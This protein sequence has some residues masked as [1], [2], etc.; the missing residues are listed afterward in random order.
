MSRSG[1]RCALSHDAALAKP[2]FEVIRILEGREARSARGLGTV[3]KQGEAITVCNSVLRTLLHNL[4]ND[5]ILGLDDGA[6]QP[7][8]A[9]GA[10]KRT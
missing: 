5:V 4:G 1:G 10:A 6:R 7:V 8:G 2:A 3:G 9:M